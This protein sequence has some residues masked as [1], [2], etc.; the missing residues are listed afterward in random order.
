MGTFEKVKELLVEKLGLG[1]DKVT[2]ASEIIKDLGADSLDLVEMLF[3]LE[4]E[5][6]VTVPEDK[7]ES[8]VTVQDIVDIID[9]AK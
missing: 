2:P 5:F 9:S 6:G 4:E 3:A 8:I 7:T 1:A